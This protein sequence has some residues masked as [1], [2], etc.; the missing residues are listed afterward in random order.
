[1]I[2]YNITIKIVPEIEGEWVT[3]QKQ[4]HI[5]GILASGQFTGH[6]FYK[7]L[8]TVEE[9]GLTYVIQYFA[10]TRDQYDHYIENFAP[11][12]REQ[13]LAKWGNRFIAFRTV[14]EER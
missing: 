13:A 3:W 2:V 14:M 11:G 8:D 4:E 10:N 7:L 6:R 1:M 9:D 5:P 12:L